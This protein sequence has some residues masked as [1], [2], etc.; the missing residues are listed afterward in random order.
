MDNWMHF[1]NVKETIILRHAF[2]VS[3][4]LNIKESST[5]EKSILSLILHM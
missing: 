2:I 1:L 3:V 5:E 4:H